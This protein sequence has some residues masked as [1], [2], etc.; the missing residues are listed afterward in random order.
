MLARSTN[1]SRAYSLKTGGL[2]AVLGAKHL[3]W[4]TP[5]SPHVILYSVNSVYSLSCTLNSETLA[6]NRVDRMYQKTGTTSGAQIGVILI[7]FHNGIVTEPIPASGC[8]NEL[9]KL[10]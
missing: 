6:S 7:Y 10:G 9:E 3:E 8:L 4:I 5:R 1:M 2:G